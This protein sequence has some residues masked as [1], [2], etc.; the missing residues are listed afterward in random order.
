MVNQIYFVTT[1]TC[2]N[3]KIFDNDW[4]CELFIKNLKEC[5]KKYEFKLYGYV[6][7]PDHVHLLIEPAK[8]FN[9]SQVIQKIKSIFAKEFKKELKYRV[10]ASLARGAMAESKTFRYADVVE[11][12]KPIWQKSFYDHIIDFKRNELENIHV[13]PAYF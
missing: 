9:I 13:F 10:A 2:N 1:K 11:P 12:G 5:K 6:V 8:S 4:A 3:N 7:M